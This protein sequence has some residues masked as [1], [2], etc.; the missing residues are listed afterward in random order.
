MKRKK[1]KRERE[2]YAATWRERMLTRAEIDA[3]RGQISSLLGRVSM[4][5]NSMIFDGA[6]K[7]AKR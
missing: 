7:V 3:G 5:E 6:G 4:S 1:T 2:T